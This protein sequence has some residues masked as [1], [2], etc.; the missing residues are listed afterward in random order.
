MMTRREMEILLGQMDDLVD[1]LV[2]LGKISASNE[3][4][5]A[6]EAVD[7]ALEGVELEQ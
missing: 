2:K 4:A 6:I 3:L 7:A 1:E 5:G